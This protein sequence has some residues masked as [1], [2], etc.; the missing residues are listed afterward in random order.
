M[1]IDQENMILANRV[2]MI[3]NPIRKDVISEVTSSIFDL[4]KFFNYVS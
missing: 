4:Y 3:S 2:L 1:S